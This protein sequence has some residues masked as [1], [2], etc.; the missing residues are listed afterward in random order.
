M[1]SVA[2]E[3]SEIESGAGGAASGWMGTV[4]GGNRG[5]KAVTALGGTGYD[6]PGC[7]MSLVASSDVVDVETP[8]CEG[9]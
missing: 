8:G 1:D 3:Q 4:G 7:G 9:G 5:S 6:G 2:L